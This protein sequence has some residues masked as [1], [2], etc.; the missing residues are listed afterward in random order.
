MKGILDILSFI[1]HLMVRACFCGL[2]VLRVRQAS[3]TR[4]Y[5]LAADRHTNIPGSAS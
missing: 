3:R 4:F 5:A 2:Y 1:F